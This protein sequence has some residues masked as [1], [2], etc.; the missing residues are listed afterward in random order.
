MEAVLI[1]TRDRKRISTTMELVLAIC[2][3]AAAV[4]F[5]SGDPVEAN[6]LDLLRAKKYHDMCGTHAW[7]KAKH[8]NIC[9]DAC[10]RANRKYI[11]QGFNV[12][13]GRKTLCCCHF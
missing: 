7:A 12:P 1:R 2:L 9:P 5:L 10:H 8:P 6:I 4:V 3:C 13:L 11:Y